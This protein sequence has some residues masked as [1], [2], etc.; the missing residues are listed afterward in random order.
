MVMFRILS[1][2]ISCTKITRSSPPQV[3]ETENK[4][5]PSPLPPQRIET[6]KRQPP[7]GVVNIK[8][9]TTV[10][11]G[12]LVVSRS[13]KFTMKSSR[14]RKR[15]GNDAGSFGGCGGGCGGGGC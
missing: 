14:R 6:A 12:G 9:G 4:I 10:K 7:P 8:K 3:V 2:F 11:D 5:S 15:F 13:S 1:C